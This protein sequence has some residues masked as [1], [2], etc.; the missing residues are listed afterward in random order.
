[1]SDQ[2]IWWHLKLEVYN[3]LEYQITR[4]KPDGVSKTNDFQQLRELIDMASNINTQKK[5][6][7]S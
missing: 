7:N 1:M 5:G 3:Y 2:L 6:I 4:A